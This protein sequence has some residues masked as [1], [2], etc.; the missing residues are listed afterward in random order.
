MINTKIAW[1]G[2]VKDCVTNN[3]KRCILGVPGA[4]TNARPSYWVNTSGHVH[5]KPGKFKDVSI[6]GHFVFVFEEKLG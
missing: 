5:A 2:L 4:V 1:R 3:L 6:T